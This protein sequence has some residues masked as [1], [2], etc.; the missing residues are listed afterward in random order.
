MILILIAMFLKFTIEIPENLTFTSDFDILCDGQELDLGTEI[1][2]LSIL[3]NRISFFT[4][5]EDGC[6]V[7]TI[8]SPKVTFDNTQ[9]PDQINLYTTFESDYTTITD[10]TIAVGNPSVEFVNDDMGEVFVLI[11]EDGILSTINY[12][13]DAD[14]ASAV[15]YIDFNIPEGSD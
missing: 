1:I 6:D 3:D 11:D 15:D 5:I 12:L 13:E 8:D 9:S 2:A 14:A 4:N 7:L 10:N